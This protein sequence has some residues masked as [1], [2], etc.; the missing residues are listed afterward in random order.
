[1][2]NRKFRK[3]GIISLYN[4]VFLLFKRE[5]GRSKINDPLSRFFTPVSKK[6]RLIGSQAKFRTWIRCFKSLTDPR[7]NTGIVNHRKEFNIALQVQPFVIHVVCIWTL[8]V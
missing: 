3:K 1:M 7:V 5:I 6:L 8:L 2:V 4:K